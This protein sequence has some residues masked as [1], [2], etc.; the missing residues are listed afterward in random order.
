MTSV[1][2]PLLLSCLLGLLCAC[3]GTPN[4]SAQL[5][6]PLSGTSW[7]LIAIQ[8]MDDAQGTKRIADP[9]LYTLTFGADGKASMRLDCNRGAGSWQ[10]KPIDAESGSVSFGDVVMTRAMCMGDSLD[11]R[12]ARDLGFV[13][14]YV[15]RDGHLFLALKMDSGIYEWAPLQKP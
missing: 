9:S 4:Q 6:D 11:T 5:S 7:Q 10:G 2:L 13:T 12:I 3:A 8:S 15:F 14:S 1:R